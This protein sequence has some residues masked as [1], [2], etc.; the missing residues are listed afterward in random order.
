MRSAVKT[1]EET[2]GRWGVI[3]SESMDCGPKAQAQ[4]S[5]RQ[6]RNER[7]LGFRKKMNPAPTGRNNA[8][9]IR[10]VVAPRWGL[11][12]FARDIPGRRS[13]VACWAGLFQALGLSLHRIHF[14]S[15][16]GRWITEIPRISSAIAYGTDRR[17]P[18]CI[19]GVRRQVMQRFSRGISPNLS[20]RE[21]WSPRFSTW[22]GMR[23]K[24]C[25]ARDLRAPVTFI[26]RA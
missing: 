11:G 14:Q 7:R 12:S 16:P 1:E 26:T 2:D 9:H 22:A 21:F 4:A 15:R 25:D 24:L 5:P 19:E 23:G 13:C 17:T 8:R 6:A 20:P 18:I 10:E 3:Q